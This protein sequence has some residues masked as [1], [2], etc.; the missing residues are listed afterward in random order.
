MSSTRAVLTLGAALVLGSGLGASAADLYGG[1][2]KDGPVMAPMA[3]PG[4]SMYV[5]IDGGRSW[6]DTPSITED[7][8]YDL[9]E[10]SI[11]SAWSVGGGVGVYF[12]NGFRGDI[13]VDRRFEAD[14]Q[15]NLSDHNADFEGVRHFGIK[16]TVALANI[17]YDFDFGNRFTPYVGVGLGI[18]KNETTAGYVE[19]CGCTTA[20]IDGD[21]NT[22]VAGAAMAG[23]AIKLRGGSTVVGGGMK[24]APMTVDNGR[25]LY[26]DVGYR[27]L[28]LGDAAT[29]P[30]T[31]VGGT[32][33]ED[34]TVHDI[35]S[36]EF[37]VGLRYDIR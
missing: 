37:R 25:G 7:H 21:S 2:M 17:Y 18:T 22:H 5:R 31:A 19:T 13:T 16:S 36:H 14:V 9:T 20:T 6:F 29:G 11:D 33:S 34:P 8:I 15:G 32:V 4:P 23:A 12:R 10:A 28:Y 26:L 35:H 1:S 24:D 30:I 27:F 3:A